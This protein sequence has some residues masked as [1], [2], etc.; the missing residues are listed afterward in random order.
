[1][2]TVW[3]AH[4]HRLEPKD[5]RPFERGRSQ[6]IGIQG[7]NKVNG[8]CRKSTFPVLAISPSH[9]LTKL[10]AIPTA[11][12]L[13]SPALKLSF[14]APQSLRFSIYLQ[15]QTSKVIDGK[16]FTGSE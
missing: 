6:T 16:I 14:E 2:S 10:A 12:F 3:H 13:S 9:S 5:A 11:S 7:K 8:N 15:E 1:M 4:N